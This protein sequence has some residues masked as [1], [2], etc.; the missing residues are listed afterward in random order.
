MWMVNQK[1]MKNNKLNALEEAEQK[2][3]KAPAWLITYADLFTLLFAFF[4]VIAGSSGPNQEKYDQI[5]NSIS[6]AFEG[7][8]KNDIIAKLK[9]AQENKEVLISKL[10]K[11]L[12]NNN[13]KK[14]VNI[15]KEPTGVLLKL[16]QELLFKRGSATIGNRIKKP[17]LKIKD[18][19]NQKNYR[20]YPLA[21]RGY[22][23]SLPISTTKF[24]SNWE[25]SSARAASVMNFFIKNGLSDR[26]KVVIGYADT[27]PLVKV[28]ASMTKKEQEI[29]RKNNRRI[30]IFI[31]YKKAEK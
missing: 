3:K 2:E 31:S 6:K 12:E 20:E 26:P 23:D 19:L 21:I 4:V 27:K 1:M 11:S 29:A 10:E 25:L 7:S 24:P 30:E 16:P 17:L 18:I 8:N 22:S 15:K 13:L 9:K 28:N 14:I 5:R